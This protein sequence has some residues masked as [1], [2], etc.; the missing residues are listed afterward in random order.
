MFSAETS[1]LLLPGVELEGRPFV[2]PEVLRLTKLAE[3]D[4]E[5]VVTGLEFSLPGLQLEE[6]V[7]HVDESSLCLSEEDTTLGKGMGLTIKLG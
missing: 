6:L 3:E 7:L 4:G 1:D 5:P 2:L